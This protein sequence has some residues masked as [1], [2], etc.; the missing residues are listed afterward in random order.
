MSTNPA[1]S[2]PFVML[3]KDNDVVSLYASKAEATDAA[4]LKIKTGTSYAPFRIYKLVAEVERHT[5]V[6][7]TEYSI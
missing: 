5:P 6:T 4:A 7:V 1:I 2:D 3:N